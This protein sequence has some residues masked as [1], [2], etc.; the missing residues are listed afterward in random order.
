MDDARERAQEAARLHR[1]AVAAARAA[2]LARDHALLEAADAGWSVREIADVT[3]ISYQRIAVI[4]QRERRAR[5][6]QAP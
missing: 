3:A 5:R 2:E 6:D 4:L 1:D